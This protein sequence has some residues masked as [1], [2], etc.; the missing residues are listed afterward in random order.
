[1]LSKKMSTI[2]FTTAVPSLSLILYSINK[3]NYSKISNAELEFLNNQERL[4]K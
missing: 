1:M 3:K 4:N 2:L